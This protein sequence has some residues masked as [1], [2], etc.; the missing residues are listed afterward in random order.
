[1]NSYLEKIL[2]QPF[3]KSFVNGEYK[4][5]KEY[6]EDEF[7]AN[8]RGNR[9]FTNKQK[10]ACWNRAVK[11]YGRDPDRWRYDAAGN[12]VVKALRGCTGSLCHEYD[13]IL[14]YSKGGE[15]TVRNCQ[16]LQSYA[17]RA[18]GNRT[19]LSRELLKSKSMKVKLKDFEMDLIEEMIYGNVK[20]L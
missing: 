20:K 3:F 14:P 8:K 17:N 11:I 1:M 19:D 6:F 10:E 13:H 4:K 9:I 15:T 18:K 12:P 16:V 2:M 5:D 7:V